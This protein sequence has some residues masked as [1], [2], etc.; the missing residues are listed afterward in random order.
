MGYFERLKLRAILR[1]LE[2]VVAFAPGISPAHR[3][4]LRRYLA[5]QRAVVAGDPRE[6]SQAMR[7]AIEAVEPGA[8]SRVDAWFGKED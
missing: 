3:T 2:G 7:A 4:I 5:L 8:F 6:V 1:T